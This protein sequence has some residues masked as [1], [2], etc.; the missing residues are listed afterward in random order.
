M[1]QQRV[2]TVHEATKVPIV[3]RLRPRL[4]RT[5]PLLT[6]DLQVHLPS[7]IIAS[8]ELHRRRYATLID[9]TAATAAAATAAATLLAIAWETHYSVTFDRHLHP[10]LLLHSNNN[11]N[12]NSVIMLALSLP[13][14]TTTAAATH[15]L[16]LSVQQQAREGGE[17]STSNAAHQPM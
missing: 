6:F 16:T 5:L 1:V 11:T 10:L 9:A 17:G 7:P 15:V 13:M 14:S 2:A 8:T 12:T 3:R 4:R